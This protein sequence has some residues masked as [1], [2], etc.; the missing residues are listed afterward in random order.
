MI[1]RLLHED[2]HVIINQ[3]WHGEGACLQLVLIRKYE[4]YDEQIILKMLLKKGADV[5]L[6]TKNMH[7]LLFKKLSGCVFE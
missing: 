5:N 7:L 2:K 1:E 3:V 4:E 6:L